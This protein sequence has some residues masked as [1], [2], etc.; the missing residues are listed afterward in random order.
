MS[1]SI[2]HFDRD[3]LTQTWGRA[4]YKIGRGCVLVNA[5]FGVAA[6]TGVA[7]ASAAVLRLPDTGL[8]RL[9]GELA[10]PGSPP[11]VA[12]ART[13]LLVVVFGGLIW[14]AGSVRKTREWFHPASTGG[15]P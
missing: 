10:A 13:M 11:A 14:A 2:P 6:G 8:M 12:E 15:Q 9:A 7:L 5:L 3:R 4:T 1:I